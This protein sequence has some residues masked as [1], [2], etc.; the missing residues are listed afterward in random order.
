MPEIEG[1]NGSMSDMLDNIEEHKPK[2]ITPQMKRRKEKNARNHSTHNI[3][4]TNLTL[5]PK[6]IPKEKEPT[7]Y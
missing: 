6:S 7:L 1:E 5:C 3:S 2:H 4:M